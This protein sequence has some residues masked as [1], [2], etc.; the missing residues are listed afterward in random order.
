MKKK[1]TTKGK[2]DIK[3]EEK[4]AY[5]TLNE[6]NAALKICFA[7][8]IRKVSRVYM[9]F[10]PSLLFALFFSPSHTFYGISLSLSLSLRAGL[11][12]S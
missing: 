12:P 1:G 7:L 2:N 5:E 9:D 10:N 4:W 11:R 3:N 6:V 8:Q